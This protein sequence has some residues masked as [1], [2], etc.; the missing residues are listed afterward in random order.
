VTPVFPILAFIMYFSNS[1]EDL[2][3]TVASE[4]ENRVRVEDLYPKMPDNQ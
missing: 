1:E 2:A 3:V 4:D